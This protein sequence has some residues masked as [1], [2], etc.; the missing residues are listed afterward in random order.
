MPNYGISAGND[1]AESSSTL[2]DSLVPIKSA[3]FGL[4]HPK[5]IES[6]STQW[7]QSLSSMDN[8]SQTLTLI[9]DV[10]D[11]ESKRNDAIVTEKPP[12]NK[13]PFYDG[14][15]GFPALNPHVMYVSLSTQTDRFQKPDMVNRHCQ[16]TLYP[17]ENEIL[18]LNLDSIKKIDYNLKEDHKTLDLLERAKFKLGEYA[19]QYCFPYTPK[20]ITNEE[21]ADVCTIPQNEESEEEGS[22]P[23]YIDKE[24]DAS[25]SCVKKQNLITRFINHLKPAEAP[26]TVAQ[27]HT[28]CSTANPFQLKPKPSLH[29]KLDLELKTSEIENVNSKLM[30]E[31]DSLQKIYNDLYT[32]ARFIFENED[33]FP[34]PS[35]IQPEDPENRSIKH[36]KSDVSTTFIELKSCLST[37]DKILSAASLK[38]LYETPPNTFAS[39][40]REDTVAENDVTSQEDVIS[41]EI[42]TTYTT[43]E[44]D[45]KKTIKELLKE[46][47]CIKHEALLNGAPEEP[48]PPFFFEYIDL[49]KESNPL[50]ICKSIVDNLSSKTSNTKHQKDEKEKKCESDEKPKK[51]RQEDN[52][53]EKAKKSIGSCSRIKADIEGNSRKDLKLKS[54]NKKNDRITYFCTTFVSKVPKTSFSFGGNSRALHR[55]KRIQK[56][57]NVTGNNYHFAC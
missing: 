1:L 56:K 18:S 21:I 43:V 8:H 39:P 57:E 45:I 9:S 33:I 4:L 3:P 34:F 31:I 32:N 51:Y 29:D 7:P 54:D 14:S 17:V 27:Y 55:E 25:Q 19:G 22:F 6:T 35:A 49:L 2:T 37:I 42:H 47:E 44:N 53:K 15:F 24:T 30:E 10:F 5:S 28:I 36:I 20:A 40:S 46:S 11:N 38:S 48:E 41:H 23:K 52:A 13:D 12:E 16:Y 26:V 50:L